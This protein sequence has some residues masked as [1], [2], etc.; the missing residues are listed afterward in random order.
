MV[1]Y[2]ED[3]ERSGSLES[4]M[5][6][7]VLVGAVCAGKS[8][9]VKSL[10]AG[11]PQLV[12][13]ARRTRGVDVH[14][15]HPFKPDASKPVELIFWDFAGHDDYHST[16]SL[17]L[18]TE[19]LF[20]LTVDLARF[21]DEPSSRGDSIYIW[22]DTLLCRT[23]G[24]VVQIVV[25]H[26]D[27]ERIDDEEGAMEEL[28]G[29]VAEHLAAKR[30]QHERGWKK[31]GREEGD[32]PA[33]PMLKIVDKI[34]AVSCVKGD[35]WPAIGEAMAHLAA[36][37]TAECLSESSSNA[38]Q[39]TG[40]KESK[41]FLSMGQEIPTI[42]ARASAVMNALRDGTDPV[43]AATLPPQPHT[44]KGMVANAQ[45]RYV[46]WDEAV[47]KW[48]MAV[49]ASEFSD[50]IGPEGATAVL[51]DMIRLKVRE[52]MFLFENE[53]LHL[54]PTWIND[55][56]RAIL[57]HRLQDPSETHFWET[58]LEAFV[59][60]YDLEYSQL[61]NTHQTFC[62]EG[63]L[64]VS[65]LK[66]LWREVKGIQK[67][68]VFDRLLETMMTHGVLFSG[69]SEARDG[70][71]EMNAALFV[72]VRLQ[73]YTSKEILET[74][75][76]RCR[77]WRCQLLF[78]V[79][80]SY[81]PPG[82]IGM[83][84]ARLLV[85]DN[86]QLHCAWSRGLSFM[87]G[88]S[89]VMLYLNPPET[90]DGKAEIEINVVGPIRSDEVQR[91]V[92]KLKNEIEEVLQENFPGLFF[93]LKGGKPRYL[94]SENALM[95]RIDTLGEHLDV[96]LDS[97]EGA[98]T[99]V[100]E[101]SRQSLMH[102]KT[103]QA[104]NYPYPH[105]VVVREHEPTSNTQRRRR[106]KLVLSKALF[107][108]FG[109]RVRTGVKKEMRLQFLCPFDFSEVPCGPG[110][111]GYC[112]GETRDWVKKVFPTLQV[113]AVVAK[114][115]LK[116]VAGLDL[117]ISDFLNAVKGGIGEEVAD[118]VL[119]EEALRRV[120]LGDEVPSTDLQGASKASYEALQKLMAKEEKKR[121]DNARPG[122]GHVDFRKEMKRVGD[123]EGGMVWISNGNVQRWLDS[124]QM[125]TL[126]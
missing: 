20:L 79:K 1:R 47:R 108:S 19:A 60:R 49:N 88:G 16:H 65:Y 66:F 109:T 12:P 86:V 11:K 103:L 111:Q 45:V 63:T 81:V 23:P 9:V 14:V 39:T 55:L 24:A 41:L 126:P 80:Q 123:G 27:D 32:M 106:K 117:E 78:R 28:R 50:E 92:A 22:L 15:E 98:L 119:D 35:D 115:A 46:S 4:W 7:V 29:V 67:E 96:R 64:T 31:R 89:E 105:L 25:T 53:L 77:E 113:T 73:R 100:A 33:V 72:P 38:G 8:S 122:D 57:D 43:H 5:L 10:I 26:T 3:I 2:F 52:G 102:L 116:A 107:R 58:Q 62:A 74:F 90:C 99:K 82:I 124:H 17:F 118:C 40:R 42:W 51:K 30:L 54:D 97:I 56:L 37:G 83:F 85:V 68:G 125:V 120:V 95:D 70:S 48:E 87:M 104:L 84:M 21:V 121:K 69:P 71:I 44:W 61:S 18:S 94:E 101:S 76:A 110:G 91:K 75:S 112:F 36:E 93:D 6:K 13:L 34:H 114:V 59:D